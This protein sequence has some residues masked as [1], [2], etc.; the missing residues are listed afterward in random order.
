VIHSQ[1]VI[2]NRVTI[3]QQVTVGDVEQGDSVAPVIGDDVYIGAGARVLGDVRVGDGATVGANAVVTRDIPPGATVVGVN[4]IL[5]TPM[6]LAS[7]SQ[8]ES[9]VTPFPMSLQRR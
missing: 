1:A 6:R 9:A 2:C 7:D 8:R 4:R 5:P 3:M